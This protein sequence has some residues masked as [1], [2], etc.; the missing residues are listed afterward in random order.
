MNWSLFL[1][2]HLLLASLFVALPVS[3]MLINGIAPGRGPSSDDSF[4]LFTGWMALALFLAQY[5]GGPATYSEQKGHPRLR[6]RHSAF[7]IGEP[8][9][10]AWLGHMSA[11]V[12]QAGL[13]P[14]IERTMLDYFDMATSHLINR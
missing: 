13:T 11:A 8:E 12:S 3:V 7:A 6:M 4:L 1:S 14:D 2:R 9:R 10:D 5:W